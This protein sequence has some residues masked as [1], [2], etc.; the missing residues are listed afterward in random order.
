M[1]ITEEIQV[2]SA[3]TSVI[4]IPM[5]QTVIETEEIK[6]EATPFKI[7]KKSPVSLRT[8]SISEIEK[9]PGGNRDISKLFNLFR[10]SFNTGK[11]K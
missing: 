2:S 11:P 6:I 5:Q 10:S 9:S 7:K 4:D 3:K 8:L 1:V